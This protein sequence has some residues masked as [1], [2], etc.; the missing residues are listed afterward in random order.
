MTAGCLKHSCAQQRAF[1]NILKCAFTCQRP[2]LCT[3]PSPTSIYAE[4][5]EIIPLPKMQT[6]RQTAFQL[7]IVDGVITDKPCLLMFSRNSGVAHVYQHMRVSHH[8]IKIS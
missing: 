4:T 7:Y 6:D 5:T 2:Q 8:G 1:R 3:K